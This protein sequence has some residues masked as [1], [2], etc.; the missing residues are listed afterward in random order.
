MG[1]GALKCSLGLFPKVLP[2]YVLLIT[3]HPV[4]LVPTEYSTVLHDG[5]LVLEDHKD[6]DGITSFKINFDSHFVTNV[7]KAFT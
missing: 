5:I 1:E 7:F 4:T 3:L 2:D 6:F